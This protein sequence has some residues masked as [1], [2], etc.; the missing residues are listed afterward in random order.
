MSGR[1]CK[2]IICSLQ[3]GS[4]KPGHQLETCL[5]TACQNPIVVEELENLGHIDYFIEQLD[6]RSIPLQE[7]KTM[8]DVLLGID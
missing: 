4:Q 2:T 7:Q 3:M 8:R 1:A 5:R 6:K